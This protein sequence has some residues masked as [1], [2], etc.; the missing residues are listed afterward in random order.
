MQLVCDNAR[1]CLR[2]A[3]FTDQGWAI[4]VSF[5]ITMYN[6]YA[7]GKDGMS[8]HYRRF[9]EHPKFKQ[10]PFGTLV[11]FKYQS[12]LE[13]VGKF[14][15]KLV[16][17]ILVEIS[18]GPTGRWANSYGAVRLDKML[19]SNRRTTACIRRSVDV[20]F[21]E[22]ASFP[23]RQRMNIQGAFSD[24]T[25]PSPRLTTDNDG[26]MLFELEPNEEEDTKPDPLVVCEGSWGENCPKYNTSADS[27]EELL[28]LHTDA[29]PDGEDEPLHEQPGE[30]REF[31]ATDA[32]LNEEVVKLRA[33]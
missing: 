18:I 30:S 19:G 2:Q 33:L 13:R 15:P 11:F 32:G 21:L 9:G 7:I 22:L 24:P 26:D 1:V 20:I 28:A 5:W 4:A 12:Q 23:L 6:G 31:E 16:P 29:D 3:G 10:Y 25:L 27:L 17:H 14:E 8:A